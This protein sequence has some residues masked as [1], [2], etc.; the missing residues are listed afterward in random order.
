[1]EDIYFFLHVDDYERVQLLSGLSGYDFK[2]PQINWVWSTYYRL[3][4]KGY[5]NV[6]LVDK[7]PDKGIVVMASNQRFYFKK[8]SKDALI[9]V[10]VADSPPWF[11]NQIN[12]SQNRFQ[13]SE[14]P[15]LFKYPL[16]MHIPHWPQPN[17][18][19]RNASRGNSFETI[20]FFGDRSQ[21]AP[22]I[23]GKEFLSEL[24]A[25]GLQFEIIEQ[26]FNDYSG[27]DCVIAIR[28]FSKDKILNKLI[29]EAGE[30]MVGR[31]SGGCGKRKF[32]S[33][34]KKVKP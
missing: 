4:K 28:S 10:T 29:L 23:S 25:I 16:W 32:L 21:L 22:E 18:I 17:L 26:D 8:F 3:K 31:G 6:H 27:I 7:I 24:K 34:N 13:H 2:H 11:Y 1:M 20:A 30:R 5:N 19:S 12:V 14:Y 15:N 9:I 33:I